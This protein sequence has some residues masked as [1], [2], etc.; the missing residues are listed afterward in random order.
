[1]LP[2]D[3]SGNASP[4]AAIPNSPR[5]RVKEEDRRLL[6]VLRELS[7][8]I[9]DLTASGLSAAT[10]VTRSKIQVSANEAAKHKLQRLSP[11]LRYVAEEVD[12]FVGERTDFS[13]TRLFFFLGR[14]WL[15]TKG[16][17]RAV[18]DDDAERLSELRWQRATQPTPVRELTAVTLGVHKRVVSGVSAAFDFKLRVLSADVPNLEGASLAWA[19]VHPY[20]RSVSANFS[21]DALLH[22]S[23]PQG[24]R[25]RDFL[26]DK[27]IVFSEVMVT[28]DAR[29]GRV[30]LTPKSKVSS[31][32]THR[33]WA[34]VPSWDLGRTRA[35]LAAYSP[36]PLDLE[37]ELEEEVVLDEWEI[38][39]AT[40]GLRPDQV[41]YPVRFRG[42]DALAIASTESEGQALRA[43][44]EN[45]RKKKHRAPLFALAHF[46][47]GQIILRPLSLLE[48]DGAEHLMISDDKVNLAELTRAVMRRA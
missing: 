27:A 37:I 36:G 21:A 1:L 30:H 29:A 42:L 14:S 38:G 28:K 22:V 11:A 26:A 17:E 43:S 48:D 6:G 32:T 9:E 25:P 16:M 8:A 47:D 12:R 41:G 46:E 18:L 35:R 5:A 19:F 39:A 24:F 33:G 23:Q 45:L 10:K 20:D 13:A 34:T 2:P 4:A 40:A 7:G 31:G 15:L 3:E 44:L